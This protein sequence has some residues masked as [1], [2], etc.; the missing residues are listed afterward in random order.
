MKIKDGKLLYIANDLLR[1]ICLLISAQR[2]A[3][4]GDS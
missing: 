3:V 4:R 2:G 1:F